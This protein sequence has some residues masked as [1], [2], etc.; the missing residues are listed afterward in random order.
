[1]A[2]LAEDP[3]IDL[4]DAASAG[5]IVTETDVPLRYRFTHALIQHGLYQDLGAGRRQRAHLRVAQVLEDA[6]TAHSAAELARHWVAAT[7]PADLDTALAYVEAAGDDALPRLAPEDAIRWYRQ[8]LDLVDRQGT[9]DPE[10]QARLLVGLG[11]A[12]RHLGDPEARATLFDAGRLAQD[13]GNVELLC[14]AALACVRGGG[15]AA[16][17]D[18]ERL[19]LIEAAIAAAGEDD[20]ALRARLLG[21]AI[22][23]M[24]AN[25]ADALFERA[26]EAIALAEAS[27]DERA[28]LAVLCSTYAAR[29]WPETRAQ[30]RID[31]ERGMELAEALGDPLVQAQM[32]VSAWHVYLE[33]AEL[34]AAD[35]ALAGLTRLADETGLAY[36]KWVSAMQ[37]ALR[38]MLRGDLAEAER[39][40]EAA[41]E[42]GSA[43]GQP[44]AL[45]VYGGQ[46]MEIRQQQDRQ[47]EIL[48]AFA[49]VAAENPG[50][51]TLDVCLGGLL[52]MH[53]RGEEGRRLI[54]VWSP[55]GFARLPM[56]TQWTPGMVYAADAAASLEDAELGATVL[57]LLA[58][59]EDEVAAPMA[60]A[61]G[62]VARPMGRVAAMLGRH[63]DADRWFALALDLHTRLQAPYLIA[64]TE[65]EW[66]ECLVARGV[67]MSDPRVG[68]ALERARETAVTFGYPGLERRAAALL[69]AGS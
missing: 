48:E 40:S 5:A 60:T 65:L 3:L 9:V 50:I 34:D 43:S 19:D 28:L 22:E 11:T 1:M 45:G 15:A 39:L 69:D 35:D 12:Q 61:P 30:R 23:V 6:S 53:G 27:G 44:E 41:L 49:Q 4:L 66:A 59:F 42:V 47:D 46:L 38:A 68:P 52:C 24:N 17:A 20:L 36:L 10:R 18:Q 37:Q 25:D 21:A 62:A 31:V 14:A 51:P 26:G 55:D 57:D 33:S 7:R 32:R 58:P 64:R 13:A 2:E 63:D 67:P 16:L 54:E 8:A 29:S 56:G